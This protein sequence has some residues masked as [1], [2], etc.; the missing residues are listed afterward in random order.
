MVNIRKKVLIYV[1]LLT[2]LLLSLKPMLVNAQVSRVFD[3]A[4][5]FTEEELLSLNNE[6]DK[7]SDN[8]DMDIVIVT[9]EDASGK[10]SRVYADDYYDNNGF[11]QGNDLDGILFL[12]DLD[13]GEVYISTSG[14]A[15]RYLTDQRIEDIIDIAFDRGLSEG[16]YYNG[17]MGFLSGTKNYLESGIPSDQYS[18][19]EDADVEK[20]L[21]LTETIMSLIA[22]LAGSGGFL[23]RTKS[24]YKMKNPVKPL[25]FRNNSII[26][27]T[28]N[29]DKLL[30]TV[31][32]HRIIP[33][34]NNNGSSDGK[35][36]T[37]QSSSG[38]THGGG[39]RKL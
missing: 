36:T 8:Y 26:N 9:T 3:E 22:G 6:A 2:F 1:L 12:I 16:D 7:I 25:N 4:Y 30:D 24:K 28:S 32:S 15:I 35:S 10:S 18:Q 39:G 14:V 27:L 11:G 34:S 29:K 13:N 19:D 17:T 31:T 37:H 21:T 5:L 33:K 23:L 20:K 38:K